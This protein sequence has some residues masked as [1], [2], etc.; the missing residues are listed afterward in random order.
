LPELPLSDYAWI[1][2]ATGDFYDL[3]SSNIWDGCSFL[4]SWDDLA[5]ID[6]WDDCDFNMS[7]E[8]SSA[9]QLNN[10]ALEPIP[11]DSADIPNTQLS[12]GEPWKNLL[13]GTGLENAPVAG[14]DVISATARAYGR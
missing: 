1:D 14:G 7:L 10:R 4:Q 5:S 3:P 8:S 13:G 11:A 2:S 6:I 12:N 9:Q